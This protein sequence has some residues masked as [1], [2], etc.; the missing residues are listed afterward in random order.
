MKKMIFFPKISQPQISQIKL[1]L[2]FAA[3]LNP[4]FFKKL[5]FFKKNSEEKIPSSITLKKPWL[6]ATESK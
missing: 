5:N 4:K 2:N 3:I 1:K 6:N